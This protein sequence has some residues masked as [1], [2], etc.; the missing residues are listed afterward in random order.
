MEEFGGS[1]SGGVREEE[2]SRLPVR[3]GQEIRVEVVDFWHFISRVILGGIICYFL[4][5]GK[6][7]Q[8]ISGDVLNPDL[9]PEIPFGSLTVVLMSG[10]LFDESVHQQIVRLLPSRCGRLCRLIK[11][12][13]LPRHLNAL[14]PPPS[15][16]TLNV[17]W[18]ASGCIYLV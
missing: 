16:M 14:F 10:M 4:D 8:L 6:N 11:T 2:G 9:D 12:K 1:E 7:V 18:C 3:A 15:A 5:L 13:E 17:S